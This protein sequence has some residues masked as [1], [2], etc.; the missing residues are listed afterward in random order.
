[1]KYERPGKTI[2]GQTMSLPDPK[3]E[4]THDVDYMSIIDPYANMLRESMNI[5]EGYEYRP[6]GW[7]RKDFYEKMVAIIGD[8]NLIFVA[9]SERTWPSDPLSIFVR[10]SVFV[11]KLG[12]RNITTYLD[13]LTNCGPNEV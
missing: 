4:T 11:N 5:P 2:K 6:I 9:R 7:M 8:D 10:A 3:G 13:S 12:I 1:M